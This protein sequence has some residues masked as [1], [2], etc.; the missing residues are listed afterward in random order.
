MSQ[1]QFEITIVDPKGLAINDRLGISLERAYQ[2]EESIDQLAFDAIIN[3]TIG[4][5]DAVNLIEFAAKQATTVNEFAI[6][7]R[8]AQHTED[9]LRALPMLSYIEMASAE[10]RQALVNELKQDRESLRANALQEIAEA[11]AELT[12]VEGTE[13]N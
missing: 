12:Q 8:L 2:L 11:K 4:D 1:T 5:M 13:A 7:M 10:E 6:C 3:G 9:N